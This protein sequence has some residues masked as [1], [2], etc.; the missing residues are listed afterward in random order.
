MCDQDLAFGSKSVTESWEKVKERKWMGKGILSMSAAIPV[1][2]IQ[3]YRMTDK[4]TM[5]F[6]LNNLTD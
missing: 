5:A 4:L 3:D 1:P 6:I 2:R